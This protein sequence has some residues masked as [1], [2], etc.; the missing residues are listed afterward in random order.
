MKKKI[1]FIIFAVFLFFIFVIFGFSDSFAAE[2]LP[3]VT[4]MGDISNMTSKDDERQIKLKYTSSDLNFDSYC[5]IKIQGATSLAYEKKNYNIK[6]YEDDKYDDKYKVDVGKGW[7]EQHKY[8]LKANWIDKTHSRN[9]V[10]ARIGA[11]LQAKY[12]LFTNAPHNGTIDGYPVEIYV[13]D[14]N[15]GNEQYLGLYTWNIPKEDWLW[16]IDEDEPNNIALGA[17]DYSDATEFKGPITTFEESQWEVEAGEESQDTID[18]FNRVINF[19]NNSSDEEFIRDFDKYINK[20]SAMNYLMFLYLMEPTDSQAKNLMMVTTDGEVWYPSMYDM[21]STWGTGWQGQLNV[22]YE[23]LPESAESEY[24]SKL[25][26]RMIKCFPDEIANRWF[27]LRRDLFTEESV[28]NEFNNFI[29]SIPT[30]AYERDAQRWGDIPGY[31]IDQIQEFVEFRIP[32]IDNVMYDLYTITPEISIEYSTDQKTNQ[33]VVA[34]FK[35][36]RNDIVILNDNGSAPFDYTHTFKDNGSY[37]F[38]YQDW[39]GNNKSTITATVNWIDKEAPI[40]EVKYEPETETEGEVTVTINSNEELQE[41]E[42]W[43]LS[44]DKLQLRKTYT[45]N[46]TEKLEIKDLLGNTASIDINVSNISTIPFTTSVS[47]SE[48]EK[49]NEDVIVTITSNKEL[50]PIE[51]WTL[52]AD[53]LTLSK[54]FES[55]VNMELEVRTQSGQ[56]KTVNIVISNIDKDKP[57]LNVEYSNQDETTDSVIVTVSSNEELKEKEGWTLSE[58]KLQQTKE[59]DENTTE[60]VTFED[61]VGNQEVVSIDI[62]NIIDTPFEV[63]VSYSTTEKTSKNVL[64]TITSNKQL[65][66]LE[67][68]ILSEDKLKLM[69]EYSANT[70]GDEVITVYSIDDEQKDVTVNISNIEKDQGNNEH[71]ILQEGGTGIIKNNSDTTTANTKIPRAGDKQIIILIISILSITA[72]VFGILYKKIPIK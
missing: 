2:E 29:N 30:E 42:G 27:L 49:T 45:Q 26:D 56:S 59:Y 57:I 33:D 25:W 48:S 22:S 72:V 14:A 64:V 20:D 24:G 60:E 52:S 39:A 37:V 8:C 28:M 43:E 9:I 53:N 18:K 63:S 10:S 13:S 40:L 34:T 5:E 21:D 54:T 31:G 41:L 71:D 66:E 47:Y 46:T 70:D 1:Y 50:Q 36:N 11:K 67:G 62:Q 16:G 51:G 23:A 35:T 32:F 58:D 68:W 17:N 65:K 6:L 38:E 69:K 19:V 7:G 4:L 15:G 44:D 55:N 61:L 3:K 12:N